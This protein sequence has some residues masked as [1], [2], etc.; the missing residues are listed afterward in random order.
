MRADRRELITLWSVAAVLLAGVIAYSQTLA[1]AWDEGFH[2]LAAQ[3]ILR[4]ERPYVDFLHPQTPLYAYFNAA[5]MRVFGE[6]WR[7]VHIVSALAVSAAALLTADFVL[8]RVE[9]RAWRLAAAL[10][11]L[12]LIAV[13][14]TI[15]W[16]GTIG[17][18]YAICLLL[19]VAAFRL[20]VRAT[21]RDSVRASAGAGLCAGAAAACSLLTAPFAPVLLLWTYLSGSRNRFRRCGAFVAG[22]IPPFLPLAWLFIQ[23][24]RQVLFG[25]IQYHG[26]YRSADWPG[27]GKQNLDVATAWMNNYEAVVLIGLAALGLTYIMGRSGWA[28]TA[29]REF[30][31]CVW[32]AAAESAYL[33]V[34]RPTF[35]RYYLFV[36]PFVA[37][38]AAVG[39]YAVAASIGSLKLPL[40]YPMVLGLVLVSAFVKYSAD[41]ID[42]FTWGDLEKASRKVDQVTP[43]GAVF[44]A[45]ESVY[46]LTR[47]MPPP[48]MEYRDSHKLPLSDAEAQRLHVL[49][50]A[51]LDKEVADGRFAT[52]EICDDQDRVDALGLPGPYMQKADVA[53]CTVFWDRR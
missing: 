19:V 27:A 52:I 28:E 41:S 35:G 26:L 44:Y 7:V 15:L 48:G 9:D 33:L 11:A 29:K 13:N 45:D 47:R 51:K 39:L 53:N 8:R 10:C 42:D 12:L 31:L 50:S 6:S 20:T 38:L 37:I 36:I 22:L 14:S 25:V 4:G 5:V 49:P 30:Y 46:F 2:L 23:A 17:Q 24:P 40:R 34:P 3:L 21:E 32:L 1:F 18:P 16:F 43:P